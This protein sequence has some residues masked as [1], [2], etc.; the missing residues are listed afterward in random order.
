MKKRA[1]LVTAAVCAAAIYLN[2][3]SWRAAV[4]QE[5]AP[6][7]IAHRGVHQTYSREGLTNES[8][9]AE[10]IEP[11]SH[12]FMENTI[13]SMRAAF[14][15]GADV[16]ELDV[17]PTTD[18]H[19]AVFHDWALDCRTEGTGTT[20]SRP[21]S[22]IK[23]LDAG[24]DYTADGGA[25]FPLRGMGVGM[26]PSLSEVLAAFPDRQFLVNFKSHEAR[27]GDMLATLLK[28]HPEWRDAVWGVYGG[29]AP[30]FR[31]DSL[32]DGELAAWSRD[33]LVACLGKYLAIGWTGYMP[34]A[35]RDS[36]VMI[37]LNVGPWLWGWPDL[38]FERFRKAGS[39]I[40]LVGPYEA[41]DPG[42]SGIDT[43]EQL[44]RVPAAFDG[45][46]W[47]NKIERIGPAVE[48]IRK[49]RRSETRDA[50]TGRHAAGPK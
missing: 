31:A 29:H 32:I 45:Y 28:R 3:A 49:K 20:R 22:Y 34:E 41:G 26:I 16:V 7:T 25:T 6:R 46:I 47:T 36:T 15:A 10:R 11:P 40:V 5:A 43:L 44:A 17:H 35:C 4:N 33:R 24:H 30:T 50:E 19:F 23:S 21:L 2:N 27:E 37:P 38:F 13:P 8:C 12:P 42:S 39:R 18:G 48:A 9:T 1:L 14:D